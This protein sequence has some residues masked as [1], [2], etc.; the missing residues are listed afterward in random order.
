MRV[1]F[2]YFALHYLNLWISYDREF[3]DALQGHD[4]AAKLK[5]LADAAVFYKIARNLPTAFDEGIGR[6]K[7][8]LDVIEAL[9][10]KKFQEPGLIDAIE[11]VHNRI[12]EQYG[13]R[14]VIS[15]TTKFLW[16]KMKSPIIIYDRR[17]SNAL[18]ITVRDI[19]DY[20]SYYAEWLRQFQLFSDEIDAAC[21]SLS[22][23]REYS[24]PNAPSSQDVEN[25]AS[26]H[27][28]KQRVFDVYLWE[29]GG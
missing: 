5:A 21:T 1:N 27:W 9:D 18:H 26:Q 19:R 12:S 7:P 22:K 15:L 29:E 8:V 10:P 24:A 28:F 14:R 2:K 6:Y 25:I 11:D 20:R 4:E 16:L 13:G 23:A 17:A 3:S